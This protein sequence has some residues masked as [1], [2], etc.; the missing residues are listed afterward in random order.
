MLALE[1]IKELIKTI[2]E[3][4]LVKL[5]VKGKDYELKLEKAV[6]LRKE[7]CV[8]DKVVAP[9]IPVVEGKELIEITSPLV[10]TFYSA[11][12]PGAEPFVKVGT[13]VQPESVICVLEAMK[14]F[15]E[16]EAEVTGEIVEV[17]V[18]DGELVEFGTPLFTVK[19][20]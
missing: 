16:V 4:S 3:S 15:T 13:K 11:A 20:V 14:L 6:E 12:E 7:V 10:G 8:A 2:E 19:A 5:E 18:K 1:E 17:L 9:V